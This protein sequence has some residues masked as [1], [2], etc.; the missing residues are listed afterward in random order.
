LLSQLVTIGGLIDCDKAAWMCGR[1]RERKKKKR[2]KKR[3]L[4][5]RKECWMKDRCGN[6]FAKRQKPPCMRRVPHEMILVE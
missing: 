5:R 3:K 2:K 6:Q 4:E 1:T